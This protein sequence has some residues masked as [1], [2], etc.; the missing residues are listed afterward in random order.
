MAVKRATKKDKKVQSPC[1][2]D[3]IRCKSLVIGETKYRTTLTRKFEQRKNWEAPDPK[4]VLSYL[5][6]SIMNVFVKQGQKVKEGDPV[7]ILEAMKMRNKVNS[8]LDGV[9]KSVNVKT[10]D[11]IP[12]GF[13]IIEIE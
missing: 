2:D 3:K 4:K 10:G 13:V 12:K 9:V 6:G 11:T 7:V 5:P 8:P 1:N